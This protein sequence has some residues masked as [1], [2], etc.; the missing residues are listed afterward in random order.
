MAKFEANKASEKAKEQKAEFQMSQ[1]DKIRRGQ[2]YNLAVSAAIS[3]GKE[4]DKQEIFSYFIFY[5]ELG[6]ICQ[7]YSIDEIKKVIGD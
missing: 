3:K 2:A 5:Y 6:K 4:I 1:E 7:T